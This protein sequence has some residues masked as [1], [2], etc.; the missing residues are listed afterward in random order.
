[1]RRGD[2]PEGQEIAEHLARVAAQPAGVTTVYARADA[3]L[4]SWA[5]VEAYEREQWQFVMVAHKTPQLVNELR[6]AGWKRSPRTDADEQ[7]E[8]WYQPEGWERPYRFLALGYRKEPEPSGGAERYSLFD[9]PEYTYR[10]FVTNQRWMMNANWFQIVMLAYNLNCWL[11]L[12]NRE[13]GGE[14]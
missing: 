14:G 2:R 3:G 10:V 4:Y 6:G 13:E 7:S 9:T 8:F 11:Q 12:F 5:T 1:M